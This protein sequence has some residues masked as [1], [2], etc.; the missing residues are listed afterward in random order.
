MVPHGQCIHTTHLD[1]DVGKQQPAPL[2]L[3][4][5]IGLVVDFGDALE[6]V[7]GLRG[8]LEHHE[9]YRRPGSK[10][11]T[12]KGLESDQERLHFCRHISLSLC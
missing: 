11:H 10:G 12:I 7:A 4:S 6:L 9:A 5:L 2:E 3:V 1:V 8:L